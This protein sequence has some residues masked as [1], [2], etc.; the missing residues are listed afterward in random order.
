MK[1]A[2]IWNEI[3]TLRY[4][5]VEGDWREFEGVYINA[6]DSDQDVVDRLSALVYD[7]T[8]KEALNFCTIDVFAEAI[9]NGAVAVEC[10]FLP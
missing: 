6:C 5:V 9:R 8:Y 7:E 4:A 2:I 3:E 10:G 1:S